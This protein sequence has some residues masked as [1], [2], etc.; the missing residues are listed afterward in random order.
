MKPIKQLFTLSLAILLTTP[1]FGNVKGVFYT[2]DKSLPEL[3]EMLN[4]PAEVQAAKDYEPDFLT[5]CE[6]YLNSNRFSDFFQCIE[7]LEGSQFRY[8]L[9]KPYGL[10][11]VYNGSVSYGTG[12]LAFWQFSKPK[13]KR[14]KAEAFY[15]LNDFDQAFKF[16]KQALD[17]YIALAGGLETLKSTSVNFTTGSSWAGDIVITAG[18]TALSAL[19]LGKENEATNATHILKQLHSDLPLGSQMLGQ[20]ELKDS[21]LRMI[22]LYKGNIQNLEYIDLEGR[23]LNSYLMAGGIITANIAYLATAIIT[24][25]GGSGF[26]SLGQTL[27]YAVRLIDEAE[28]TDANR[29]RIHLQNARLAVLKQDHQTAFEQFS[30]ILDHPE[31]S[32]LPE[33]RW[34]TLFERGRFQVALNNL[35]SA[36]SDLNQALSIIESTRGNLS[37]ESMKIGFTGSKTQV[38][39]TLIQLLIKQKRHNEAF[40][41]AERSRARTMIDMLADEELQNRPIHL[42][43]ITHDAPIPTITADNRRR[44]LKRKVS[45][46]KS[47]NPNAASLLAVDLSTF[48][49]LTSLL[50]RNETLVEYV[51]LGQEWYAFI[52][53][54]SKVKAVSLGSVEVKSNVQALRES[55]QDFN[56]SHYQDRANVLYQ[57]IWAPIEKYIQTQDVVLVLD[58]ALHYLPFTALFDG[59]NYLVENYRSIRQLPSLAVSRFIRSKSSRNESLLVLGNPTQDLPGA[60]SEAMSVAQLYRNK[61]LLL[62]GSAKKSALLKDADQYKYLHVASHG[63]YTPK[64]PLASYLLLAGDNGQAAKLTV[65]DLYQTKLNNDLVVL[66]GC[67]TGLNEIAN[68]NDLLGFTRGFLF[69]GSRSIISSLWLVDDR[70]T[71]E[72]MTQFHKNLKRMKTG[73]ALNQAQRALLKENPHPYYWAAFQQTGAN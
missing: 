53:T 9:M 40:H 21:Y 57:T 44:G 12:N 38:Y 16:G 4:D 25:S 67:E 14:L 63:V 27:D 19:Q 39:Q 30:K 51:K 54:N 68:G 58:D 13:S 45:T 23:E 50:H 36:E 28:V 69:A 42:T 22:S 34:V 47:S 3:L 73:E 29:L 66:S 20:D 33:L 71:K 26:D 2:T 55:I 11:A 72:L 10:Q 59:E 35:E 61:K 17:Q 65:A 46:I 1:T 43:S 31:I 64:A 8:T 6:L 52:V 15:R 7:E 32:K 56:N 49:N 48:D 24:K 5:L 62:Q 70:A 37:S 18:I 60:E 41:I